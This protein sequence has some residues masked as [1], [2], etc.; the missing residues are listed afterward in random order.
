MI[1]QF[2]YGLWKKTSQDNHV[3]NH[4]GA[5]YAKNETE[6]SWPIGSCADYGKNQIRQLCD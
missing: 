1:D 2:G 6:F 3:T 5:I 4:I